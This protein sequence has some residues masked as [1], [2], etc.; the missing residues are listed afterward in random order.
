MREAKIRRDWIAGE[1]AGM[2]V[3]DVRLVA[4]AP[5]ETLATVAARWR[6]SPASCRYSATSA[7]AAITKADVADLVAKLHDRGLARESIRKTIATLAMVLDHAEVAPN[8]AR[9]V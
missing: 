3:P 9:K 5:V 1:L 4:S 2:R 6:T 8:P 7:P